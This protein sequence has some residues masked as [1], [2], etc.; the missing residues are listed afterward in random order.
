MPVYPPAIDAM[1]RDGMLVP[2]GDDLV[3]LPETLDGI[4][5]AASSLADGFAV[6]DF[7]DALDITRK[8][9]VPLL[10]WMDGRGITRRV[11]DG[12]T[13]TRRPDG[14]L[15]DGAPSR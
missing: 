15:P 11:G 3:Y 5:A 4:V 6:A 2:V 7:R 9:A 1:I 14:T 12:R 10:E 8:H 13:I